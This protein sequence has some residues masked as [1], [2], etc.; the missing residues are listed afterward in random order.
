MH[1]CGGGGGNKI[2]NDGRERTVRV[3]I[4]PGSSG[5]SGSILVIGV[6][7]SVMKMIS[8]GV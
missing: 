4:G 3:Q 2:H 6:C 8:L 7:S 1:V 5:N